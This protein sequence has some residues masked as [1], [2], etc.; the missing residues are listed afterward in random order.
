MPARPLGGVAVGYARALA[1]KSTQPSDSSIARHQTIGQQG[2]DDAGYM[3][4]RNVALAYRWAEDRYERPPEMVL[5]L[6][7]HG[8]PPFGRKEAVCTKRS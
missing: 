6:V 2:L 7:R 3:E 4:G 8:R 1:R 5:D